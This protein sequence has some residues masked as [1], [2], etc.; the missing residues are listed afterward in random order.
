MSDPEFVTLNG[1][2]INGEQIHLTADGK[3]DLI[4]DSPFQV[5]PGN[6]LHIL[7][8]MDTNNSILAPQTGDSSYQFR[9]IVHIK[10]RDELKTQR[11][12]LN[13]T[14]ASIDSGNKTFVLEHHILILCLPDNN[15]ED[16]NQTYFF[17]RVFVSADTS[18]FE[19][20][21]RP[22]SFDSLR[23]GHQ[24]LVRGPVSEG[25]LY[26]TA[27]LLEIGSYLRINGY[28]NS[29]INDNNQF[30]FTPAEAQGVQGDLV[31]QV[32]PQ[33]LILDAETFN[34]LTPEDLIL[35]KRITIRG[36]LSV[37]QE[38]VLLHVSLIKI[39]QQPRPVHLEGTIE[40]LDL[41]NQSFTLV[42]ENDS[43]SVFKPAAGVV[44]HIYLRDGNEDSLEIELIPFSSLHN[45]D[46]V[47]VIGIF[48]GSDVFRARVLIIEELS[49]DQL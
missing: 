3:I 34:E 45:G 16:Q 31:V 20:N 22:G 2:I 49:S 37:G 46:K 4:P 32:F 29:G 7:L 35:G 5:I 47:D 23:V 39:K 18:I 27:R 41:L 24:V 21:G 33:S 8:D 26:A 38:S 11:V 28:I 25:G 19:S 17:T 36:V 13:G 40:E 15:S 9:P 30:G 1:E 48:E 6:T 12:S 43:L 14:I 44:M 10:I 42:R